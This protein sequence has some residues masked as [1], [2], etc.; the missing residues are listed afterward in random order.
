MAIAD[1]IQRIKTNIANAYTELENKG[2]TIPEVKNSENLASTISTVSSGGGSIEEY[3]VGTITTG[4]SSTGAG[5][6][7]SIKKL[8][9][10]TPTGTSLTYAFYRCSALE[11]LPDIDYTN[12]KNFSYCFQY[13][14]ALT[15]IKIGNCSPTNM[16]YAFG[17]NSKLKTLDLS[18]VDGSKITNVYLMVANCSALT[19]FYPPTEYGKGFTQKSAGYSNYAL[20]FSSCEKLTRTSLL[21]IING[22]YDLNLTYDVANGGTLYTQ[23]LIL[24]SNNY[25]KL[26][27]GEVQ[28]A[29][30][31]GWIVSS[32]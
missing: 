32:S 27:S 9:P 18:E 19:D 1:E 29:T 17:N 21:R 14:T 23:K 2:A 28:I 4:S 15:E 30:N 3:I 24:G 22:L 16:S 31:K 11:S 8:P 25:S 12:V 26:S 7:K 5:I 13:C 10:L 6:I 20:N